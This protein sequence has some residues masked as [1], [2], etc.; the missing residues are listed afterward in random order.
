MPFLHGHEGRPAAR[1]DLAVD[2]DAR[3][4][5]HAIQR[6]LDRPT[7]Q[8]DR[9]RGRR[10]A[11]VADGQV[12]RDGR[13]C[14]GGP[15]RGQQR[16][17]GGPVRVAVDERPED[18]AVHE[19]VERL[20]LLARLPL[21]DDAAIAR[22]E[23]PDPQPALVRR[24]APEA[25][26]LRRE[27]LL[28]GELTHGDGFALLVELVPGE[29][30]E[31]SWGCPQSILNRSRM[32][33]RHPGVQPN[34]TRPEACGY[35][36]PW[37]TKGIE[38]VLGPIAPEE[39]GVTLAHEHLLFDLRALWDVPPPERAHLA[40]A[41]LTDENRAEVLRDGYQSKDNLFLDDEALATE[42]VA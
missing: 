27:S 21:R 10:R 6:D 29:G 40:D 19:P 7:D 28:E 32:P 2:L 20:V 23:A 8:A 12:G 16:G 15:T 3:L 25:P 1:G 22:L 18:P 38:T 4:D 31:P 26:A 11:A 42:E 41:P 30:I 37:M 14:I 35:R 5:G 9:L 36:H 13:G 33:F 17:D 24:S 34:P 39:L